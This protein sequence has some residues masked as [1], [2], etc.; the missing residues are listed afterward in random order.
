MFWRNVLPPSSGSMSKLSKGRKDKTCSSAMKMAS[1]FSSEISVY[2]Q[3][4]L[5]FA[6]YVTRLSVAQAGSSRLPSAAAWVQS[7]IRSCGNYGGKS[8]TG[9]GF[10]RVLRFP[11]P[12]LIPLT[13]V[14]SS[15]I[16]GWYSRPNSG[17]RTKW[18]QS[19]CTPRSR[20]RP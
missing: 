8:G 12:L 13:A 15:I 7:Q 14:Y 11:L 18:T 19:R 10:L 9:V 2:L 6:T 5:R 1:E 3:E 4:T 20:R 16:S 17:R